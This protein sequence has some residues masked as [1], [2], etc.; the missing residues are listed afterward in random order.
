MAALVAVLGAGPHGREIAHM[1]RRH[2][3]VELFDDALPGYRPISAG[4]ALPHVIGAAWP[5]ARRQIAAKAP[6][7]LWHEGI[8]VFPGARISA[9]VGMGQHTH[10]GYNTV[11]SHGCALGRF[12]TVCSGAVLAGEVTVGDD[13]LIGINASVIHGGITIGDGAIIG[14]GAVVVNDVKPGATVVGCPAR[15]KTA[16]WRER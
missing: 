2:T 1:L 8:V 15:E 9:D 6:G 12:V 4:S 5:A 14:A 11:V 10:I 13:V 3:E 7:R 16:E